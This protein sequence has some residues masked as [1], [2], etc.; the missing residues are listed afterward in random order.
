MFG[1]KVRLE[2]TVDDFRIYTAAIVDEGDHDEGFRPFFAFDF[3][4]DS[5]IIL[6]IVM[7][8]IVSCVVDEIENDL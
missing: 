6:N 7:F 1:R 5:A 4:V 3:D 2:D 8:E